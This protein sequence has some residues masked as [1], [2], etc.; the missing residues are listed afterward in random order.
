MLLRVS[1]GLRH[2]LADLA[3]VTGRAAYRSVPHKVGMNLAA[4]GE[5][6]VTKACW[7]W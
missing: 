7:V 2:D 5:Q 1:P 3:K 4:S 6:K